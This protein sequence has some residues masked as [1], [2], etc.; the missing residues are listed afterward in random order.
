MEKLLFWE[1]TCHQKWSESK[2][3]FKQNKCEVYFF[4]YCSKGP[5]H[6][7]HFF[8]QSELMSLWALVV[9]C[10]CKCRSSVVFY[11]DHNDM[12]IFC[13]GQVNGQA[14]MLDAFLCVK[15]LQIINVILMD[16]FS[17]W[18]WVQQ[19]QFSWFHS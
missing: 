18:W 14:C 4:M 6:K 12:P 13:A 10:G 9:L 11:A 16:G 15:F 7:V 5:V 8:V 19:P 17:Y 2:L 1:F 3:H